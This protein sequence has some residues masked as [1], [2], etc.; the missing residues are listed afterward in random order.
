MP[1][2]S[3]FKVKVQ[4]SKVPDMGRH[5]DEMRVGLSQFLDSSADFDKNCPK[6]LF[7]QKIVNSE[8]GTVAGE[9]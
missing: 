8:K 9:I 7:G 6:N 1:D 2:W 5:Q 3:T 4:P